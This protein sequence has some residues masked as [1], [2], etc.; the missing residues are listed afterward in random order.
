MAGTKYKMYNTGDEMEY[1]EVGKTLLASYTV[2]PLSNDLL[3][4]CLW[5]LYPTPNFMIV[6]LLEGSSWNLHKHFT[7]YTPFDVYV[8][9]NGG[10]P[11]YGD[12]C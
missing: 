10:M 9:P 6:A 2:C 11:A 4:L 8:S 3:S 7:M 12:N 1:A 5:S